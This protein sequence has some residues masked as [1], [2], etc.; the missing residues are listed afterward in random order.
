MTGPMHDMITRR[1]RLFL[2]AAVCGLLLLL[3][4]GAVFPRR[5]TA[6]LGA[7]ASL[8]LDL[9]HPDAF[10][11]T[12]SLARM[13]RDLLTAPLFRDVL[14]E[15]FV[16]HYEQTEGRLSLSGT[17]RRIA[18]ERDLDL[19]DWIIRTVLDQPAEVALWKSAD[20]RLGHSLIT[21]NRNV[22]T[23]ILEAAARVALGD[24]QLR[25]VDGDLIV[26]GVPV[27]VYALRYG[28]RRTLLFAG[29]GQRLVALSD[30]GMLTGRDGTLAESGR[31]VVAGLLS[32]DATARAIYR[33]G[34]A[35]GR[36]DGFDAS[37]GS[38]SATHTIAVRAPYLSFGYQRFFPGVEALRFDFADHRWST[39][40]RFDPAALPA[41]GL[42]T[43]PVWGMLP[44]APSACLALPVDWK[45]AATL[46]ASL[47]I[48]PVEM[49]A[50][51]EALTGPAA[52]CW[53]P[54][55]RLYTPIFVASATRPLRADETELLA[56]LFAAA[57]GGP[58]TA[59]ESGEGDITT[60][61][62]HD[63]AR[64]WQRRVV[65]R[66]GVRR[67]PAERGAYFQVTLARHRD[68]LVF[69]PDDRLVED[70][71]AVAGKRY[72]AV[73]DQLPDGATALAIVSAP[74]LAGLI[75]AETFA[76]LPAGQE[77]TF[78]NAASAHLVPR[79]KALGR[80]PTYALILPADATPRAGR[81]VSLE[82][83]ALSP[84]V[85]P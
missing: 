45:A 29:H 33:E 42:H 15:D 73:A 23:R 24:P 47:G 66:D 54:K 85:A 31:A 82:W 2:G 79:L 74:S 10:I 44:L 3:A 63:G 14:T 7:V 12:T 1:R 70:V 76:S 48:D 69:S 27:P 64:L 53:Y 40:V 41:D 30:A 61:H 11:E 46:V 35:L 58:D 75:E 56:R 26:D 43:R 20:G 50:A 8:G 57:V 22:V 19:G 25:R 77:P 32:S 28:P 17:L 81:W 67:D 34:F 13:P 37:L 18:Y 62:L 16:A 51:V 49:Q 84:A 21:I 36:R 83:V 9:R 80:Y 68:A 78:R 55:S 71:L 72:P 38:P 39:S 52:A 59:D 60:S 5:G 65:A 6:A 4:A